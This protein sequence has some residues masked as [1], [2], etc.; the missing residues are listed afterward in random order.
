MRWCCHVLPYL[1]VTHLTV[2]DVLRRWLPDAATWHGTTY[3]SWHMPHSPPC[4]DLCAYWSADFPVLSSFPTVDHHWN[5]SA[6]EGWGSRSFLLFS[7][8][9]QSR[10]CIVQPGASICAY[11]C[12]TLPLIRDLL[13]PGTTRC[14]LVGRKVP[15]VFCWPLMS[16]CLMCC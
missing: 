2:L 9:R 6:A 7:M 12:R 15:M 11:C 1:S 10:A 5:A 16:I 14:Y 13:L 8:Q 3:A 4:T